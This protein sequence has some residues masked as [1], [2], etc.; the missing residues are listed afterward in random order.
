M[1]SKVLKPHNREKR[2]TETELCLEPCIASASSVREEEKATGRGGNIS[3][4]LT[5]TLFLMEV[6]VWERGRSGR[7]WPVCVFFSS[8]L[9]PSRLSH[10]W[11]VWRV[12]RER[13]WVKVKEAET[14]HHNVRGRVWENRR[15]ERDGRNGERGNRTEPPAGSQALDWPLNSDLGANMNDQNVVKEGWVQKRGEKRQRW[16]TDVLMSVF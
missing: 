8:L 12:E 6:C 9:F 13:E 7:E 11:S 10:H 2:Q 3:L 16:N 1:N 14:L 15:A 4:L 5:M